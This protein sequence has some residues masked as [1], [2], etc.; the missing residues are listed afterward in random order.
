MQPPAHQDMTTN[1]GPLHPYWP[2]HLKLDNFVPN[3]RPT[4]HILV[5]LFSI[6]GVLV[7][8]TWLLSSRASVVPLGTWRRLSLCWFAVCAFIHMVIEGWFCLYHEV[9][10]GDQAFLS[11]LWKEYAKGDSRYIINDTF[12]IFMETITACLWGPLSLWVVIAF[13]RQQPLRFV[14]QLVVSAGQI[15]GDVLYFLTEH[16][17]GFQHG[18]LGHPIYFWFYF[19]FMNGLWL[20]LPGVLVFDSI[21]QLTHA[22][23]ML[24]TKVM[25]TK[26]KN[27]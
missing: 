17:N 22:Q 11:Q 19:V 25:K 18:E 14:L 1:A 12:I 10:L 21:K 15:Y 9:L 16:H 27:N 26:S 2:R 13:L 7:A 5:G 8:I 3:D 23:S 20:V 24:D 6:S 4:W